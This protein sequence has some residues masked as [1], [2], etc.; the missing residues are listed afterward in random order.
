MYDSP[1]A[2]QPAN[3]F[4]DSTEIYNPSSD[5]WTPG[6][7]LPG[8]R[9]FGKAITVRNRYLWF[10]GKSGTPPT[11]PSSVT[12]VVEFNPL[13]GWSTTTL[14]LKTVASIPVVIPYNL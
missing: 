3:Q 13:S 8:L 7:T 12:N 11:I 10:G 14:T 5:T 2:S 1:S 9:T 6:P 4:Y